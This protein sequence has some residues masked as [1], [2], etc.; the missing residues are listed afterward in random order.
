MGVWSGMEFV[1]GRKGKGE[2]GGEAAFFFLSDGWVD[3][4]VGVDNTYNNRAR[5]RERERS[6]SRSIIN[7][8]KSSQR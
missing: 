3:G 5:A 8:K 6:R 2:E 7:Q 1:G 4:R